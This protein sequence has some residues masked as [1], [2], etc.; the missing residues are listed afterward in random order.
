[1]TLAATVNTF[2]HSNVNQFKRI[3]IS[4]AR[5]A[6]DGRDYFLEPHGIFEGFD[7]VMSRDEIDAHAARIDHLNQGVG[8]HR[9][10]I[11]DQEWRSFY[12]A[13]PRN[14]IHVVAGHPGGTPKALDSAPCNGCGLCL[15]LE[16]L[17]I[18]HLH[19]QDGSA[20]PPILKVFRSLGLTISGPK[21]PLGTAV[22]ANHLAGGDDA[23]GGPGNAKLAKGRIAVLVRGPRYVGPHAPFAKPSK[24]NRHTA[25]EA[26]NAFLSLLWRAPG[27]MQELENACRNSLLNLRPL[28]GVCNRIKWNTPRVYT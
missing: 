23:T 26:G 17:Q 21:G 16:Q 20:L 14:F 10:V 3:A 11:N 18:D 2:F 22:R 4:G 13:G 24:F 1:M 25:S 12:G 8:T 7:L 9:N 19:P 28:C 15:P 5:L 6:A 27:G